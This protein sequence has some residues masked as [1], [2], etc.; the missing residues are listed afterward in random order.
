[1]RKQRLPQA[2][3]VTVTEDAETALEES[4]AL[5]VTLNMLR[6]EKTH[7]RLRNAQPWH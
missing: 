7:Q 5:S 2:R 1:M 6:N 3:N 4:S